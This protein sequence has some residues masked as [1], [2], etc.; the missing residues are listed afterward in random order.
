MK[1]WRHHDVVRDFPWAIKLLNVRARIWSQSYTVSYEIRFYPLSWFTLG[2]SKYNYADL[3]SL[4]ELPIM[5]TL[6][7]FRKNLF[8]LFPLPWVA[9]K[10]LQATISFQQL[11]DKF[12][13]SLSTLWKHGLGSNG[14]FICTI[15]N[16]PT[17]PCQLK[18][19]S[20]TATPN[21]NKLTRS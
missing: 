9:G 15:S 19:T 17:C 5:C 20:E 16:H 11:T 10:G 14:V 12:L 3:F 7:L 21:I 8:Y 2:S 6:L 13:S 1:K 18:T 4:K